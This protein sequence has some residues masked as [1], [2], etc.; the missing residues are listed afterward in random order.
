MSTIDEKRVYGDRD[1]ATTLLAATELGVAAVSVAGDSIGEFRLVRRCDARDL[2]VVGSTIAVATPDDVLTAPMTDLDE[3]SGAGIG[4]ATAVTELDG[5]LLVADS[6]ERIVR[7]P[8]A[9]PTRAATTVGSVAAAVTALDGD[10]L[11]TEDG[12]YRIGDGLAP[13]GLDAVTDVSTAGVPLA[14]TDDGLYRLGPGWTREL[15]GAFRVV[16]AEAGDDSG[17]TGRSHAGTDATLYALD[18]GDWSELTLPVDERVADLAYGEGVYAIT[19]EG[20][21][22]ATVGDGWRSRSIGLREAR[23]VVV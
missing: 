10:L 16:S 4:P 11:G 5:D 23:T 17:V 12:V 20:T 7:C 14:A 18:D 19:E 6:D 13:V 15:D 22:L 3:L 2:A 9:D 1:G 8:A 21:V